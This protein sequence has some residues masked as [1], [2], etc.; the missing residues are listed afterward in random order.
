M[1]LWYSHFWVRSVIQSVEGL[2]YFCELYHNSNLKVEGVMSSL[3]CNQTLP[4]FYKIA[5]NPRQMQFHGYEKK[6]A[7]ELIQITN[8]SIVKYFH[9]KKCLPEREICFPTHFIPVTLNILTSLNTLISGTSEACNFQDL[10]W[11]QTNLTL[12]RL[13]I[14]KI[15]ITNQ[16][17]NWVARIH[18]PGV[19]TG[20]LEYIRRG[21]D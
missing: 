18:T 14:L 10:H 13:P 6:R 5:S 12:H 9:Y 15:D 16:P 17:A 8:K 19:R 3:A 11:K 2:I 4:H 20:L 1:T 7:H 21:I